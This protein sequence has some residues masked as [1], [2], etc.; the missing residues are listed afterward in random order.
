ML[1]SNELEELFDTVG[2]G[3]G[4]TEMAAASN[5]YKVVPPLGIKYFVN[6][7]N[8]YVEDVPKFRGDRY[9]SSASLTNG[10]DITVHNGS[11]SIFRYTNSPIKRIGHWNLLSGIDMFFTDFPSGNDIAAVRWSLDKSGDPLELNGNDSEFIQI[12]VQDDMSDLVS[13]IAKAQGTRVII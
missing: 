1:P 7:I 13:H 12:K 6:R 9:G 2:D 8:I 11:G 5:I 10:I 3:S 4:Q